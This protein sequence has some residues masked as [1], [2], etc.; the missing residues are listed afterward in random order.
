[1]ILRNVS[2][3]KSNRAIGATK[4]GDIATNENRTV[5]DLALTGKYDMILRL[6]APVVNFDRGSQP[7][8]TEKSVL[9][10]VEQK[11]VEVDGRL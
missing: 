8:A 2:D 6:V 3:Y 1:M 10:R 11:S 9:T 5:I 4:Y 7:N